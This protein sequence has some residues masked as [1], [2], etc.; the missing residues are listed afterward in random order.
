MTSGSDLRSL[1][2]LVTGDAELAVDEARVAVRVG[3]APLRRSMAYCTL[4]V[5]LMRAGRSEQ[6][7]KALR[8]ARSQG[9]DNARIAFVAGVLSSVP[10]VVGD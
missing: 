6:A 2:Y 10:L 9:S 7:Q 3:S 1:Y 5:A 8:L 4:A